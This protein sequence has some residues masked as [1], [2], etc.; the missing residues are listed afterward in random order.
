[1]WCAVCVVSCEV[2]CDVCGALFSGFVCCMC[3]VVLLFSE[4]SGVW[5]YVPFFLFVGLCLF[6]VYC[7]VCVVCVMYCLVPCDVWSV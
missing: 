5:C 1:M 2:L 7:D 3:C 4:V 6:F